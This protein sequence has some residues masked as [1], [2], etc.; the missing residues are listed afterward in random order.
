MQLGVVSAECE[1][2]VVRTLLDDTPIIDDADDVGMDDRREAVGDDDGR[3]ALHEV[4][5]G[6]LHK[7][8]ALGIEAEVA[9]SR[10]RIGGFL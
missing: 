5:Q 4:I 10:M 1:E 9:S 8:L 6:T 3:T 7:A 2:L